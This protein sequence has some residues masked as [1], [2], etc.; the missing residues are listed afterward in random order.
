MQ[1]LDVAN[2]AHPDAGEDTHPSRQNDADFFA[3]LSRKLHAAEGIVSAEGNTS[4]ASVV[5]I[6]V[7]L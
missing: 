5:I 3:F 6:G 4:T 1:D 7:R 2:I